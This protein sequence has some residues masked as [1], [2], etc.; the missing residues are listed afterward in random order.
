MLSKA[1]QEEIITFTQEI[2][3][4]KSLSGE[5]EAVA[6]VISEKMTSLDYDEVEVDPYG[7]VIAYRAGK[8]AKT[9]RESL[10]RLS[11]H[12]DV[13]PVPNPQ[14]WDMDPFGG[15]IRDGKI[16]GRGASDMK[17]PLSASMIALAHIPREDFEGTLIV[18]ASV[19][20]EKHEGVAL[21]K[22]M[23][24]VNPDF[25]LICEPNGNCLGIGQKGRAGITVDVHGKPAHSS[26][27]HLGDLDKGPGQW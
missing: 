22:V 2:V 4:I 9:I 15:E 14:E 13:V 7:S 25:V 17:G 5:E 12:M 11:S 18:S 23:K 3:R 26:V 16:W 10:S 1:I 20:E 27:P 6:K 24:K 8:W 21:R 19:N